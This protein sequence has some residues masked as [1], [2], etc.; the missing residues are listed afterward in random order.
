MG[1]YGVQMRIYM[2]S[3]MMRSLYEQGKGSYY[4]SGQDLEFLL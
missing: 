1:G 2:A 3:E 4:L